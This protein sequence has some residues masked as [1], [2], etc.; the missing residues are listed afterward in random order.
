MFQFKS[1]RHRREQT[2]INHKIYCIDEETEEYTKSNIDSACNY[3]NLHCL[4]F[5]H[6]HVSVVV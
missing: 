4:L 2:K 1:R 6:F 3:C 5:I